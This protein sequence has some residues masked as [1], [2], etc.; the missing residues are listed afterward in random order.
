M[1][2]SGTLYGWLGGPSLGQPA[3]VR[4]EPFAAAA[5]L[6]FLLNSGFVAG[7][8]ALTTLQSFCRIWQDFFLSTWPSY[9]FGIGL[10]VAATV[11]IQQRAYW[12]VPVLAASL[13]LIHRNHKLV[14]ERLHDAVTDPLTGLPNQRYINDHVAAELRKAG[15]NQRTVAI[16]VL[17]LDG[18]KEINDEAGHAVGDAVLRRVAKC[19][20]RSIHPSEICAR[21]GGDEFVLVMPDC[22]AREAVRRVEAIQTAVAASHAESPGPA[23]PLTISAGVAIYPDDGDRFDDLFA[24]ADSRMYRSKFQRR[25]SGKASVSSLSCYKVISGHRDDRTR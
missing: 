12:L 10:A 18:F 6:F 7:A 19:L 17:D 3:F 11:G 9:V 21:H 5:G 23:R 13:A 24:A 22:G 25:V 8:V 20:K 14:L 16:A 15:R 4:W 2:L 1:A